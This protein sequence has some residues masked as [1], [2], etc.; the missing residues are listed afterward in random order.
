MEN[1][2]GKMKNKLKNFCYNIVWSLVLIVSYVVAIVISLVGFYSVMSNAI[3]TLGP[4][5]A[6][7]KIYLGLLVLGLVAWILTFLCD[8]FKDPKDFWN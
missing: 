4:E 7:I 6:A 5:S 1:G 2:G 3:T 8:C